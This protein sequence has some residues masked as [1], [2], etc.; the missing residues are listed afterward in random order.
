MEI[1]AGACASG[2]ASKT[3]IPSGYLLHSHGKWPIYRWFTWVYLLKMVI[4]H[5]NVTN[6]QMVTHK[7]QGCRHQA[8]ARH[9]IRL[10]RQLSF[11]RRR[12]SRFRGCR[13]RSERRIVVLALLLRRPISHGGDLPSGNSMGFN[14]ISWSFNGIFFG[15]IIDIPLVICY[16]AIENGHRNSGFSHEKWWCSIA[17]C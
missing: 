4:F 15:Y 12:P 17:K 10:R 14:G 5:G 1:T 13:A 8:T 7:N 2:E 9:H 16:I 3:N 6:H 11:G